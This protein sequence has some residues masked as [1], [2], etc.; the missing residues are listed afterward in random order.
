MHVLSGIA[1]QINVWFISY[2]NGDERIYINTLLRILLS[3]LKGTVALHVYSRPHCSLLNFENT[4][5]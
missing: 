5:W 3:G 4:G 1:I 2:V